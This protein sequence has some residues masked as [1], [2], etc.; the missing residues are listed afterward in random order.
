MFKTRIF[1][2]ALLI[3]LQL[4]IFSGLSEVP[5]A[6]ENNNNN[7]NEAFVHQ[8]IKIQIFSYK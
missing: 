4:N 8:K 3:R 7:N 1:N 6:R 5:T 2:Q